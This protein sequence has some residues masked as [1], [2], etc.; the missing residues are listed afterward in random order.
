MDQTLWKTV[1]TKSTNGE[2]MHLYGPEIL[3]KV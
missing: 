2:N 1:F 3:D